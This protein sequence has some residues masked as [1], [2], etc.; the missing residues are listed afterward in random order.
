MSDEDEEF[1]FERDRHTLS[2]LLLARHQDHAAAIVAASLFHWSYVGGFTSAEG[3]SAT[4]EV[5]PELFD[6]AR[7][8]F[9]EAIEDGCAAVVG[10][11]P[12][13]GVVF[14]VHRPPY[15]PDWVAKIVRAL[16]PRWVP[17]ERVRR[18]E[19]TG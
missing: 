10:R 9:C 5:P 17:S 11:E 4:L 3:Y 7:T 8:E 16:E 1:E 14:R 13:L 19:V 2:M 12:F 6:V 15:E 18:D